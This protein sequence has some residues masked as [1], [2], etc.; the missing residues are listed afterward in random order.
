MTL[1]MGIIKIEVKVPELTRAIA[2]F[3]AN[4]LKSLESLSDEVKSAV[5]G[6]F[7]KLLH[8]EMTMFLGR[9]DQHDNKRNG[10]QDREYALKGVGAVRIRMP[11]DRKRR[12]APKVA[13]ELGW[14][15]GSV[16]AWVIV[17]SGRTNRR[18]S[19]MEP[20]NNC[21]SWVTKPMRS[22]KPSISISS[23]RVPL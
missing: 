2:E 19:R 21:A 5:M 8:A 18:F 6:V 4:R 3:K 17:A 22:R 10:Y 16:S 12:L 7:D 20:L 14:Q 1:S 23:S 15:A 9:P 11:V 13:A